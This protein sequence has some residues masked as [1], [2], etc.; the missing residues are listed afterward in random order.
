MHNI[1]YSII[2]NR[3]IPMYEMRTLY[4]CRHFSL[5][6]SI[7]NAKHFTLLLAYANLFFLQKISLYIHI[8]NIN[9]S[10]QVNISGKDSDTTEVEE[11]SLEGTITI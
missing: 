1:Y 9:C 11:T 4:V 7:I 2:D 8:V 6:P 5:V 10:L 3:D